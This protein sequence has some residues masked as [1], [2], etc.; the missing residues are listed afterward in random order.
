MEHLKIKKT[1]KTNNKHAERERERL[2][3]QKTNQIGANIK[4]QELNS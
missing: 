2:Q 4:N 1:A 3:L